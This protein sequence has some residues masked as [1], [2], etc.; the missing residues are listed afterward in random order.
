MKL[1]ALTIPEDDAQLPSWL[2]RQLV[3]PHLAALIAELEAVHGRPKSPLGVDEVIGGQLPDVLDRGLRT[4]PRETIQRLLTQPRLLVEL[5]ARVLVEGSSYW[6]TVA[7]DSPELRDMSDKGRRRFPE[8]LRRDDQPA[9]IAIRVAWFQRPLFVSLVTTAAV[10]CVVFAVFHWQS[11]EVPVQTGWGWNKPGALREDV[12][13]DDYLNSLAD[14]AE[15]WFNQQP[16]DPRALAA[17]ISQFR[18]GCST[19][20]LADHEPL[21]ADDRQWLVGK[22]RAW[23]GKLDG[24]IAD[25]ES[26]RDPSEVREEAS[27]TVTSLI[28]ALRTHAAELSG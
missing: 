21:S 15:D 12:A 9:T 7:A 20:I 27:A 14:A 2:E 11:S 28:S 24:H 1:H 25:L 16:Q 8:F 4:L 17:R 10:L 19:L 22:C 23:A 26:G 5:Q 13:A 6:D 3:G 18:Q